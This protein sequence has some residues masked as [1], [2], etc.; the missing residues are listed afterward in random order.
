MKR[1]FE[2][3]RS[4]FDIRNVRS[5]GFLALM[6]FVLFVALRIFTPP[7][8]EIQRVTAPDGSREARLLLVYYYSDPGYKVAVRSGLLWHTRLYL[9]EYQGGSAGKRDATLRWSADSQQLFFEIN[10]ET[11]WAGQF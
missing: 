5:L 6:G 2:I 9:P 7:T 4:L 3:R 8:E 11:I 10:G 1:S